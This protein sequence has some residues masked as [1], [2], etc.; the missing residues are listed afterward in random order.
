MK[1]AFS[2]E[3]IKLLLISSLLG[4]VIT[5][6]IFMNCL[7]IDILSNLE[8]YG[9]YISEK[10]YN[11]QIN[12]MDF[13]RYIFVYRIK[14]MTFIIILGLT[15]YRYMFHS[16]FLFYLG[17]K[18]SMLICMLTFIKGK[19]ALLWYIAMTQPQTILYAIII[20]YI[21]KKMDFSREKTYRN[22]RLK[23]IIM[24][25]IGVII[26]CWIES[27]LNITFLLKII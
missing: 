16:M 4:G 19:T 8:I 11:T 15:V 2:M 18:H 17:V 26:M 22:G 20:Y 13:F 3:K 10:L 14:E 23:E 1:Y 24:C 21:I 25:V 5:G 9:N 6:T 27:A 12:K 7:N